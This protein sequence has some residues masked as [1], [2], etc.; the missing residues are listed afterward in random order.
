[1]SKRLWL[2]YVDSCYNLGLIRLPTLQLFP[3]TFDSVS[4]MISADRSVTLVRSPAQ[5]LTWQCRHHQSR[6]SVLVEG[7]A[8]ATMNGPES[9]KSMKKKTQIPSDSTSFHCFNH[10]LYTCWKSA[11]SGDFHAAALRAIVSLAQKHTKN[12]CFSGLQFS[13]L[14]ISA[15]SWSLE[16]AKNLRLQLTQYSFP[17]ER[18]LKENQHSTTI[19]CDYRFRNSISKT[20]KPTTS[21]ISD[22]PWALEWLPASP[23]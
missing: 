4:M 20:P 13:G 14:F 18:I 15:V 12:E 17:T 11:P 10:I 3:V 21:D 8:T 6:D 1:M 23:A 22:H 19:L 9:D 5:N 16:V 7:P 2:I